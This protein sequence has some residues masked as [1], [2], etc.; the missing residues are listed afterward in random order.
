MSRSNLRKLAHHCGIKLEGNY[1]IDI[2]YL[3]I[4]Q[5][6]EVIQTTP[7]AVIQSFDDGHWQKICKGPAGFLKDQIIT[8]DH[9]Y[10]VPAD[11]LAMYNEKEE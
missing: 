8:R 7:E 9:V 3:N 2:D 11:L 1:A 4:K 10:G 5:K 6:D